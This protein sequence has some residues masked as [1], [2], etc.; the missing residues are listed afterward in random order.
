[1]LGSKLAVSGISP[2]IRV[3]T[4]IWQEPALENQILPVEEAWDKSCAD[5]VS[6]QEGGRATVHELKSVRDKFGVFPATLMLPR[7]T[8]TAS[9]AIPGK[10]QG[11][12]STIYPG[13]MAR[14]GPALTVASAGEHGQRVLFR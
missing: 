5:G 11:R 1:M 14:K 2:L 4:S 9:I 3:E 8:E 12:H 6:G 13:R 7:S 10:S